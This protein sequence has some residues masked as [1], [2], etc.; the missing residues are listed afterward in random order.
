MRPPFK[1]QAGAQTRVHMFS[2]LVTPVTLALWS[3]V[4]MYVLSYYHLTAFVPLV[5]PPSLRHPHPSRKPP[6]RDCL[7][8]PPPLCFLFC[9]I[10]S[11]N[12]HLSSLLPS[13][14]RV[15]SF[16]FLLLQSIKAPKRALNGCSCIYPVRTNLINTGLEPIL[17]SCDS[18]VLIVPR[19]ETFE[20]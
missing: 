18:L 14:Y 4:V 7:T 8:T 3:R 12:L 20:L 1:T 19:C 17:T 6:P 11:N 15:P 16:A 2:S 13:S 5:L 9:S 10:A